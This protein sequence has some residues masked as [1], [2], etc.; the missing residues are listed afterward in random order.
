MIEDALGAHPAVQLAAAVGA[1]DAYAG[2]LPVVYATL[3][4]GA[5]AVTEAEL[6]AFTADR[7]DEAVA[8][9]RW[10]QVIETMPV[11]NVGKIY[12][13]EL[14]QR[15]ACHTVQAL[16]DGVCAAEA[17]GSPALRC[18][19]KATTRCVWLWPPAHRQ[20][21]WPPACARCSRPCQSPCASPPP[22]PQGAPRPH[23]PMA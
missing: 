6:L 9:P 11:T 1:P 2:E 8:R 12:K 13:P 4:P 19:P 21:H 3:V 17:P 22:P 5:Q 16:V 14:R 7:V 10:V 18:S 20:T 15:A 23:K